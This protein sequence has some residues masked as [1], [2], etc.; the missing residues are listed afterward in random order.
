MKKKYFTTLFAL[1]IGIGFMCFSASDA[2][3]SNCDPT[4]PPDYT[5]I[6]SGTDG[7][8]Q[9]Q[10]NEEVLSCSEPNVLEDK[11]Y[12][13]YDSNGDCDNEKYN[14]VVAK[15]RCDIRFPDGAY[16]VRDCTAT[17]Y[18]PTGEICDG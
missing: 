10:G 8:L 3:A 17:G 13:C 16:T 7:T 1:S 12:S 2:H 5:Y 14:R 15:A 4:Y 9:I 6:C 11:F 18:Y